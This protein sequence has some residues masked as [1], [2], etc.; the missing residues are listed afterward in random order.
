ME[1]NWEKR[2]SRPVKVGHLT[3]GGNAPVLV[4]SMTNTDPSDQYGTEDNLIEFV[5]SDDYAYTYVAGDS[6]P[7]GVTDDSGNALAYTFTVDSLTDTTATITFTK[8]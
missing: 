3:L 5:L 6:L 8:R 2:G 4:Q 7:A 1:K